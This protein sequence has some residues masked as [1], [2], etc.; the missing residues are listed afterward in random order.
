MLGGWLGDESFAAL[1][2][3]TGSPIVSHW[4]GNNFNFRGNCI[5]AGSGIFEG[6]GLCFVIWFLTRHF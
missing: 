2:F 3:V 6:G 1:V 4:R 5:N